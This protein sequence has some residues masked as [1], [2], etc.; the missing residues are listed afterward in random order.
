MHI[1]LF[2]IT[3]IVAGSVMGMMGIGGG[4][5]IVPALVYLAG[6]TQSAAVGTSLAIL[7]PPLGLAAAYEYYRNGYV[8]IKAAIIIAVVMIIT[9]WISSRFAVKINDTYLKLI[10]GS[11]IVIVGIFMIFSAVKKLNN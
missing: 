5:I 1:L 9:S 8:D 7:L 3:G 4:I 10:F 6:F 11:L 2:V